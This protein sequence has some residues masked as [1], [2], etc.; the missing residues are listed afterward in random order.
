MMTRNLRLSETFAKRYLAATQW[1]VSSQARY[2]RTAAPDKR[3]ALLERMEANSE[4][5]DDA[6]HFWLAMGR[7][8][9]RK[10]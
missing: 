7:K 2:F 1:C 5:I 3:D 4:A 6:L 10:S 8:Q 9:E